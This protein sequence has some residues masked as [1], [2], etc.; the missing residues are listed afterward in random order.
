MNKQD[1]IYQVAR[2]G[3]IIARMT[4]A[5]EAVVADVAPLVHALPM[6]DRKA[7]KALA[8]VRA[9]LLLGGGSGE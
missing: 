7:D 4:E 1:L 3:T 2:Q 5:L 9:A 6:T 8:K